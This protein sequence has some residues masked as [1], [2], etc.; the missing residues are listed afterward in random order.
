MCVKCEGLLEKE[1]SGSQCEIARCKGELVTI[2]SMLHVLK[3]ENY[4]S[5]ELDIKN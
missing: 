4:E 2:D 1:R 3:H 5:N